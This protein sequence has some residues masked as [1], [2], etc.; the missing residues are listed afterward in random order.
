MEEMEKKKRSQ[1]DHLPPRVVKTEI[2]RYILSENKAVSEPD[3][4]KHLEK[5]YGILDKKNIKDHLGKLKEDH[6][7]EKIEPVRDGFE[8][9]WDIKKIEDLRNIREHFSEIK[10]N[11]CDKSLSMILEESDYNLETFNGFKYY[12]RLLL[13][14]TFFNK[15]I[16]IG[17]ETLCDRAWEIYLYDEGFNENQIV[18][19]SL[20]DCYALYVKHPLISELP[21]GTFLEKMN[22]MIP[23]SSEIL[24]WGIFIQKLKEKFQG[25]SGD[26]TL[27]MSEE[28]L[29]REEEFLKNEKGKV[30]KSDNLISEDIFLRSIEEI[31]FL[32]EKWK[33][34]LPDVLDE[35]YKEYPKT[36]AYDEIISMELYRK[37]YDTLYLM[38][39]LQLKFF[40]SICFDLL[41]DC[42]LYSDILTG[43]ATP[44]ELEFATKT[45]QNLA[46]FNDIGSYDIK[47]EDSANEVNERCKKWMSD[48][49]KQASIIMVKY[50]QPSIFDKKIYDNADD[51]YRALR[52]K[53]SFILDRFE[54]KET[55]NLT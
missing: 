45:K 29:K 19:K 52:D 22:E 9:K 51:V 46:W 10:L 11:E 17:I 14:A 36:S 48:D 6:C 40:N 26:I 1:G 33:E 43:V 7:I 12:I 21:R 20:N 53:Y 16:D 27:R 47:S 54:K 37:M 8:N 41:F 25:L 18:N 3:I 50:K 42:F 23:K 44:E 2:I 49:L 4:R 13:S 39:L 28:V 24:S 32:E 31:F 34:M 30:S 55:D 38:W 35:V 15:C 5:K